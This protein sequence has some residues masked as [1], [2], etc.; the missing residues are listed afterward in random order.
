MNETVLE[1]PSTVEFDG[2]LRETL[3]LLHA[4][5]GR[6]GGQPALLRTAEQKRTSISSGS[7]GYA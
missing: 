3:G 6:L 2:L 1:T 4:H 7:N 5:V